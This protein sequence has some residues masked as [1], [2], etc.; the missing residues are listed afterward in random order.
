MGDV[1]CEYDWWEVPDPPGDGVESETVEPALT[2]LRKRTH[3][4]KVPRAGQHPGTGRATTKRGRRGLASYRHGSRASLM[5]D[6]DM[7]EEIRELRRD[8][9]TQFRKMDS[10]MATVREDV[11]SIKTH[12]AAQT[13]NTAALLEK[14]MEHDRILKGTDDH[15]GVLT[16]V[17]RLEC[18]RKRAAR[19]WW[20]LV[21]A[22][23]GLVGRALPGWV[24]ANEGDRNQQ[25]SGEDRPERE[26]DDGQRTP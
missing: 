14:Q 9:V 21:V 8:M 25:Q 18:F 11:A 15:D 23:L 16:R 4:R 19:Y 10:T 7:T 6:S 2:E 26:R 13:A 20:A 12:H 24:D 22:V 1:F 5:T 17:S 3:Y